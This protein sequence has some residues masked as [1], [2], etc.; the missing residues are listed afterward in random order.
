MM[1]DPVQVSL[2]ASEVPPTPAGPAGAAGG[3]RMRAIAPPLPV[4]AH[5]FQPL[6]LP[7]PTPKALVALDGRILVANPMLC[8]L[9]GRTADARAGRHVALFAP[10]DAPPVADL[11]LVPG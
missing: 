10:P 2:P 6:F 7:A 3:Q 11:G 8:A 5:L 9:P 1:G 4:R